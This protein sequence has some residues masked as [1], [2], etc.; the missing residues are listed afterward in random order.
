MTSKEVL[1]YCENHTQ[2]ILQRAKELQFLPEDKLQKKASKEAW[3]VMECLEHLNRYADF[4]NP[5]IDSA[6]K[7][8]DSKPATV[9][10]SGLLGGYFAKSMLPKAQMKKMKTFKDMNPI[11]SQL[12]TLV[13]E[14]FIAHQEE[15]LRLLRLA[16]QANLNKV[17][18]P[19]SITRL[20]RL[21]L[22]DTFQFLVNHNVRHFEQIE[23]CLNS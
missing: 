17:K 15:F 22:G 2:V 18:T 11:Y 16:E 23:N 1:D 13:L 6:L 20:I 4:Y 7:N 10:K 3:S 12:P 8:A 9:F 21:K 5:V 14:R 19:I